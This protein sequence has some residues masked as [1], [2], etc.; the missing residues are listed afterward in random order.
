[1]SILPFIEGEPIAGRQLIGQDLAWLT[2]RRQA[3]IERFQKTGLPTQK[4]ESWKYTRLR[5]LDDTRYLPVDAGGTD[6]SIDT[7]PSVGDVAA[8]LVFVNGRLRADL[9]DISELPEGV[10]FDTLEN[11]LAEDPL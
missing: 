6:I 8:R 10:R 3:G 2:T 9:S 7:V 1:M 4:L 11:V 5:P